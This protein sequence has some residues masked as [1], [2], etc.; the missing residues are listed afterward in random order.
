MKATLVRSKVHSIRKGTFTSVLWERDA[1]VKKGCHDVVKKRVRATVRLGVNYENLSSVKHSRVSGTM[2]SAPSGLS[3][4][5][6]SEFPYFIE[7]TPKGGVK[8][9]YLRAYIGKGSNMHT[10]WFLNGHKVS[11]EVISPMALS[12]ELKDDPIVDEKPIVLKF[13][14]ILSIG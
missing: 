1:K 8:T 2:P 4:G 9:N 12:S 10:E 14:D 6:W 11:K 3:W 13:D 7:H 5:K